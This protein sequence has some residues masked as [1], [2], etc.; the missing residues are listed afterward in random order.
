MFV[1]SSFPAC[2]GG[3]K[4]DSVAVLCL[5]ANPFA[6]LSLSLHHKLLCEVVTFLTSSCGTELSLAEFRIVR[7]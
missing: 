6:F 4:T 1:F 5:L 7:I 2:C 3:W